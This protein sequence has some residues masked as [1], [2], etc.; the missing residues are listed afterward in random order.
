MMLAFLLV[1]YSIT[2][3]FIFKFMSRIMAIYIKFIEKCMSF[4]PLPMHKHAYTDNFTI[5]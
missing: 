2:L 5:H 4:L 1:R 3:S